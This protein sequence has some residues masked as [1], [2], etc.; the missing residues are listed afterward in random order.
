[1]PANT[2]AVFASKAPVEPTAPKQGQ[3]NDDGSDFKDFMDTASN[4]VETAQ[5]ASKENPSQN[6]SDTQAQ[7]AQQAKAKPKDKPQ[8]DESSD[9]Q[10]VAEENNSPVKSEVVTENTSIED[11]EAVAAQLQ[12]LGISQDQ[13]QSMLNLLGLNEDA[14]VDTLL[15]SIAQALNLNQ[16]DLDGGT[17]SS[18]LMAKIQQNKGQAVELL[19]QAGLSDLEAKNVLNNLE[20][21]KTA[22]THKELD[23]N[24]N[25]QTKVNPQVNPA[26]SEEGEG[27]KDAGPDFVAQFKEPTKETSDKPAK[28]SL[29]SELSAST[30]RTS[31]TPKQTEAP[32]ITIQEPAQDGGIKASNLGELLN[33]KNAQ[34]NIIQTES[35]ADTQGLKGL[36]TS[37]AAPDIQA[38]PPSVAANNA[39]K[40]LESSKP[41]L[42]ENLL[43]RGATET[44]I[45]NQI[46]EKMT[47]RTNGAQ[48]EIQ[49]RLDPPSLG[50]VRMNIITSG[51]SVRATI[52][53]ENHAVK[54]VIETNFNQLRD[55]MGD[56]GLKL[57]SFTVTVGGESGNQKPSGEAFNDAN[58]PAMFDEMASQ[59]TEEGSANQPV[60]LIF[61]DNQSISVIA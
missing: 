54:Q 33:D 50:K 13:Y 41:I 39:V 53:A 12:E 59:E 26:D 55:A 46:A 11:S 37:K 21:L 28:G 25:A 1:M 7:K 56:Q 5:Q 27:D 32:R 10:K 51:D 15:Q 44:K 34:A 47:V 8:A 57:D 14:D 4:K 23:K 22:L 60:S 36:E 48:N 58:D 61:G 42:P 43:A 2:L 35:F 49:V 20:S 9:Y 3:A 18:D 16:K 52:V 19:K 24:I 29:K 30:Q 31:E 45:I 40:A 17:G 38:Q 6:Q